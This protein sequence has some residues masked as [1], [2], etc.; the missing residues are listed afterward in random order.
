MKTTLAVTLVIIAAFGLPRMEYSFYNP[1]V[2][3]VASGRDEVQQEPHERELLHI[4]VTAGDVKRVAALPTLAQLS[5]FYGLEDSL[6]CSV[7]RSF[8]SDDLALAQRPR[9]VGSSLTLCLN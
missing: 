3:V 9:P 1:P 7:R 4:S 5:A 8:E 6:P 2:G